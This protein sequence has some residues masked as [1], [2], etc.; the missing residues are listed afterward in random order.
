MVLT[1]DK[2]N[3]KAKVTSLL[4]DMYIDLPGQG[5]WI[6]NHAF[7]KGGSELA[8]KTINSNFGLDIQDYVAV[9]M[10]GFINL[11]DLVGGVEI[12]VESEEIPHINGTANEMASQRSYGTF[13]PITNTGLQKLNGAQ[14]MAYAR[15]RVVGRDFGR[16]ARQREVLNYVFKELKSHGTLKAL[17]AMTDILPY[18]ETSLSNKDM[19][20]LGTTLMGLNTNSIEEFRLPVNGGYKDEFIEGMFVMTIDEEMNK[21]K[22]HE[23]IY[24]KEEVRD[25]VG[26]N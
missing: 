7:M 5:K 2:V 23:F 17:S 21:A 18:V 3:K 26:S 20:S 6:L 8:I 12:N 13:N 4:R 25:E 19:L 22:L 24:G 9:N 10:D 11:V 1:I 14:A 15:I 16:T